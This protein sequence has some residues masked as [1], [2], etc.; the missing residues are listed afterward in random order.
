MTIAARNGTAALFDQSQKVYET[1]SNPEFQ[2]DALSM[3]A[4]FQNPALLQRALE[5]AV[6]G[7]V[8]NQDAVKQ[9]VFALRSD[10]NRDQA[11]SFIQNNWEKVQPLLTPEA[12]ADLVFATGS[13]CTADARASVETFFAQ[14]QVPSAD[15][16]VKHALESIDGC[17]E[18]RKLQEPKLKKWLGAQAK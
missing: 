9:L 10:E 12:G 4:K 8:R 15:Q 6:S 5:Y 2:E 3:L 16:S 1:S 11:W 13:F 7:K 14:H 17:I 18:L